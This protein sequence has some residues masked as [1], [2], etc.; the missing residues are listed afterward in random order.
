MMD[1]TL[2][3]GTNRRNRG[4]E[5]FET[6]NC[7]ITSL[8]FHCHG[9]YVY[10]SLTFHGRLVQDPLASYNDIDAIAPLELPESGTGNFVTI[11]FDY[12]AIFGEPRGL[13]AACSNGHSTAPEN[14]GP[15]EA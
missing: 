3:S 4:V 11:G 1:P 10:G 8:S 12:D 9:Q 5:R 13:T 6:R 2:E 14:D 7:D 15:L